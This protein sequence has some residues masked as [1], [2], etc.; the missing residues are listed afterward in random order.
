MFLSGSY[1]STA[2]WMIA[3]RDILL[4]KN[5]NVMKNKCFIDLHGTAT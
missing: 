4:I 1:Q 5:K 3:Q 2:K